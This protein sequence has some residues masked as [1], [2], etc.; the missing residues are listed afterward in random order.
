MAID[1]VMPEYL[2]A[3]ALQMGISQPIGKPLPATRGVDPTFAGA[4]KG[5]SQKVN[6]FSAEKLS[7]N[8]QNYNNGLSLLGEG[9][10]GEDAIFVKNG[11][12]GTDINY[13]A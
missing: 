12:L 1:R 9:A 11:R 8:N 2:R 13:F 4:V 6:P 5:F 10:L 7:F 3:Q